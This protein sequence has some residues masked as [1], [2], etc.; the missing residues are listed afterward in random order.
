MGYA[1]LAEV[2]AGDFSSGWISLSYELFIY[3]CS[4]DD[5]PPSSFIDESFY[6]GSSFPLPDPLDLI[7]SLG[8][9]SSESFLLF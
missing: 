4:L 9:F 7:S 6:S 3:P 8:L 5:S 1:L 2:L